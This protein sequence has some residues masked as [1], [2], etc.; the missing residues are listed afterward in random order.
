MSV[1]TGDDPAVQ[2]GAD[3]NRGTYT[4]VHRRSRS[5]EE[6]S[7]DG[8]SLRSELGNLLGACPGTNVEVR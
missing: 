2:P 3:G 4:D 5:A 1:L 8:K 6:V 7:T